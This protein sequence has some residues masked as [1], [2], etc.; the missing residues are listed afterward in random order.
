MEADVP[1]IGVATMLVCLDSFDAHLAYQIVKTVLEHKP[2]LVA[3]HKAAEHI[4]LQ[5]AVVGSSIPF[6]PG[7]TKYYAEKGIKVQ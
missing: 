6:H 7:A 2:D 5:G 1:I 4:S 3:V